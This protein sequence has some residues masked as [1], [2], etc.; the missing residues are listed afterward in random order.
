ML[1]LTRGRGQGIRVGRE[2]RIVVLEVS[3]DQ[4]RLG[5]EAP[6]DQ[7]ILRDELFARAAEAND[8]AARSFRSASPEPASPERWIHLEHAKLGALHF[9]AREL[10]EIE[11]IA[12][13]PS[14]RRFVLI[15]HDRGEGIGWLA[16]C[17]DPTLAFPIVDLRSIRPDVCGE[18]SR[19]E[20]ARVGAEDASQVELLGILSTHDA[21][22][23]PNLHAPL[24]IHCDTRRGTQL[25]RERPVALA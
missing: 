12:G 2:V 11:E 19:E 8:E 4:V 22:A 23:R 18:L 13:F 25:F 9:P 14:A 5:I 16:S 7:A 17:E 20:L 1:V 6:R 3:G 21:T 10:I 15:A 24:L